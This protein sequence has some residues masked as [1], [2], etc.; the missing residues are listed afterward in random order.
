MKGHCVTCM[1]QGIK[2][3]FE[4]EIADS[5]GR[6]IIRRSCGIHSVRKRITKY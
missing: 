2:T 4:T 3:E 6:I 5:L 1:K